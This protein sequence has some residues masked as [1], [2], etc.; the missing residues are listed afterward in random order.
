MSVSSFNSV[1]ALV[2][3]TGLFTSIASAS[4]SIPT[5]PVGNAG[6]AA[7]PSSFRGRYGA[8][9]YPFSIGVTEVTN[10][11][12]VAFLNAKA[13]TD[14]F[15]LY[16]ANMAGALGGITRSGSSGTY[17]YD[18]RDGRANHPV[19]FVSFWDSVRFANWLHNGQG[20]GDTETGAYTLDPFR[21]GQNAVTRNSGWQW[22]VT[23]EDEWHKAAYFQPATDGGDADDYWLYPTST[24]TPPSATV[25]N[26]SNVDGGPVAV[27]SY[28]PNYYGVF[29]MA[30]NVSE[31]NESIFIAF[32][33]SDRGMRGG[34]FMTGEA[35]TRSS[36]SATAFT[37]YESSDVGFRVSQVP[38]PAS[39]IVFV[40]SA[41]LCVRR[42]R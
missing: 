1:M 7:D 21:V 6:N 30:G 35:V 33:V 5:M 15:G 27:Q 39:A 17:T 36:Y 31:W 25:A 32:V 26:L 3:I 11:Q 8:V 9:A 37:T 13:A 28:G 4:I 23:S 29:D 40:L 16:N 38:A 34:S 12:Y 20:N 41:A 24:N 14:T 10:A 42:R 22:A 2:S 19:N 18:V